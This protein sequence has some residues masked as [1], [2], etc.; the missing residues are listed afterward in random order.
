MRECH[1]QDSPR[2]RSTFV[3]QGLPAADTHQ[4]SQISDAPIILPQIASLQPSLKPTTIPSVR[5]V[6]RE[7]SEHVR[8]MDD[9]WPERARFGEAMP[10]YDASLSTKHP[11]QQKG[12]Q[13][14]SYDAKE[15]LERHVT[16]LMASWGVK[17]T[18]SGTCIVWPR[19]WK[20]L[21]PQVI[22]CLLEF[23]NCP[24]IDSDRSVYAFDDHTTTAARAIAWFG[25]WPRTGIELDNFIETGPYRRNDG[26]HRCHN[27][28]CLNP[29][30]IVFEPTWYNLHRQ[31]CQKEACFLRSE[32]RDVPP[33]C[34][35]HSPPCLMQHA[36]LTMFERCSIQVFVLRCSY[37]LPQTPRGRPPWHR[38]PTFEDQLPLKF[39][40]STDAAVGLR[41]CDQETLTASAS[42]V[43][44]PGTICRLCRRIK[45]FGR[46]ADLWAHI[47]NSH[48]DRSDEEKARE[49]QRAARLWESHLKATQASSTG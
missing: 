19:D 42:A 34:G 26:S 2:M 7:L 11:R 35:L 1:R 9:R 37:G 31:Q 10:T 43:C 30:H 18:H 5:V 24:L 36:S 23:E 8:S 15:G 49:V 38:Y 28:L 13:W 44:R 3:H 46:M 41:A 12:I 47:L 39:V 4:A 29:S 20:A 45:G 16:R 14:L 48:A 22:A 6:P 27:P 32:G 25:S 40:S 17:V 33:H 21:E